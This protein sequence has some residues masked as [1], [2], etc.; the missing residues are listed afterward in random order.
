MVKPK[1]TVYTATYSGIQVFEMS[2]DECTMMRRRSDSYLNATQILKLGGLD[3]GKR[4][5][6]LEREVISQTHEKIQGGYGKYQGTWV[7]LDIGREL[8]ERYHVLDLLLPL[9]DFDPST[10]SE[11]PEKEQMPPR[12]SRTRTT[13][14]NPIQ[15]QT[16]P[17]PAYTSQQDS[18]STTSNFKRKSAPFENDESEPPNIDHLSSSPSLHVPLALPSTTIST[19]ATKKKPRIQAQTKQKQHPNDNVND[20]KGT[21]SNKGNSNNNGSNLLASPARSTIISKKEDGNDIDTEQHRNTLLSLFTSDDE[22]IIPSFFHGAGATTG[23]DWDLSIDE[24]GHT[25]LHWSVALG[26]MHTVEWLISKGANAMMVNSAG[27][28]PLMRGVMTTS[29]YD[30][31]CFPH[32]LDILRDSLSLVDYTGRTVLHHIL[33]STLESKSTTKLD[34]TGVPSA[35]SS[36]NTRLSTTSSALIHSSSSPMPESSAPLPSSQSSQ[37]TSS[38]S[39]SL[40]QPGN[41]LLAAKSY[42]TQVLKT[43]VQ[44]SEHLHILNQPDITGETP[45]ALARRL[46]CADL[47]YLM[48]QSGCSL[49]ADDIQLGNSVSSFLALPP[50]ISQKHIEQPS[51]R[52]RKKIDKKHGKLESR[53][54]DS[55]TTKGREL[56][57]T[58]QRFVDSMDMEFSRKLQ[59]KEADVSRMQQEIKVLTRQLDD[60]HKQQDESRKAETEQLEQA[61][62]KIKQLEDILGKSGIRDLEIGTVEATS[63]K[64]KQIPSASFSSSSSLSSSTTATTTCDNEGWSDREKQQEQHIIHLQAQLKKTRDNAQNT[65]LL[66]QTHEK[67]LESLVACKRLI[68]ACCNLPLEKVDDF[69][70]PLTMAIENDP[71]DLDFARV[72]GFMEKLRQ[73]QQ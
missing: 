14:G 6:V 44:H 62:T 4:T 57:S 36:S 71:P 63:D 20:S 26:R 39:S 72:I 16:S 23:I 7:P 60:I 10:W 8:A 28:T 70:G 19:N 34:V 69:I 13:F 52:A 17:L 47:C 61:H 35:S 18:L 32:M 43:I 1:P 59:A 68:A 40:A 22:D 41:R 42:M 66:A 64:A 50:P 27:E 31:D 67:T 33:L 55:T 45:Y 53:T 48:E 51:K 73:H 11:L 54:D 3:K 49:P 5:K 30:H 37:S 56:A 46:N 58:V 24:Q 15:H 2:V 29:I 12:A 21:K 38:S 25:A 9:V 65:E